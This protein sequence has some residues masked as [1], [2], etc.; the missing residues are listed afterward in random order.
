MRLDTEIKSSLQNITK[1]KNCS[2]VLSCLESCVF[3]NNVSATQPPFVE[4]ITEGLFSAVQ[5]FRKFSGIGIK[6]GKITKL[7]KGS[8]IL[9]QSNKSEASCWSQWRV[10]GWERIHGFSYQFS[11]NRASKTRT[12]T[13]ST[14][15]NLSSIYQFLKYTFL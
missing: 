14:F 10:L 2:Q 9:N 1:E 3:W 13:L 11:I 4:F 12:S 15:S 6:Y 7:Q 8:K 5:P